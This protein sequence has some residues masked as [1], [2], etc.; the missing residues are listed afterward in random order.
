MIMMIN[1]SKQTNYYE[2]KQYIEHTLKEA[3]KPAID[4]EDLE[5]MHETNMDGEYIR[6]SN[7]LGVS[8]YLDVTSKNDHQ[9]LDD[10]A[11]IVL[12]VSPPESVVQDAWKIREIA[13]L[14]KEAKC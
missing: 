13:G 11:S 6:Y 5:Y 14:F 2:R 4:F 8:F 7:T 1:N 3:F 9:I 12:K 10:V